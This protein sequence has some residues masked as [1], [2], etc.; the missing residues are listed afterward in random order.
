MKPHINP[1]ILVEGKY[2]KIKLES[3]VD[4]LIIPTDGFSI[5]KNKALKENIKT[6]AA[7]HGAIILTDSDRAGFI[8]RKYLHDLLQACSVTDV[9]VPDI[10]GKEKRKSVASAEGKLGVEGM[11]PEVLKRLLC[12]LQGNTPKIGEMIISAD[13]YEMGLL[14]TADSAARRRELQNRLMLPGRL[15]KNMLLHILN[16]RFTKD[17]FVRFYKNL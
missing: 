11:P 2:D 16:E 10:Y 8:I 4:A 14:G 1:I 13:L 15:N 3:L 12:V 9:Y 7:A 5:F 6:L 17:E